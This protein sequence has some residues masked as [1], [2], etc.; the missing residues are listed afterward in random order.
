MK[1]GIPRLLDPEDFAAT[2]DS[3]PGID[4]KSVMTYVMCIFRKLHVPGITASSESR[5]MKV[6]LQS[7]KLI[8]DGSSTDQNKINPGMLI[9]V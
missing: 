1:I 8:D 4:K 3:N 2:A 5:G 9:G 6:E 7:P